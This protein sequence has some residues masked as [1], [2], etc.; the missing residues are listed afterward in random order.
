MKRRS[1]LM[2]LVAS[3]AVLL[4]ALLTGCGTAAN[5]SLKGYLTLSVN[6]AIRIEYNA[7]G[8]VT[9]LEGRNDDGAAIV[10]SY[11]D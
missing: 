11:T 9:G 10:K 1:I 7:D 6:P 8:L 5:D 2:A 3:L 4:T